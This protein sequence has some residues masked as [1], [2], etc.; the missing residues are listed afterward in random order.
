M[1]VEDYIPN[2]GFKYRPVL[3]YINNI[4][5]DFEVSDMRLTF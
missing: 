5:L 2:H 1:M 3:V 4:I